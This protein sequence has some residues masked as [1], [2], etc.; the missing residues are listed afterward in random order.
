[1]CMNKEF[2]SSVSSEV[3]PSI[4][5]TLRRKKYEIIG[6]TV[7]LTTIYFC[8]YFG[9]KDS[10]SYLVPAAKYCADER[11]S[12]SSPDQACSRSDLFAF[13]VVGGIMQ[14]YLG[15]TGFF[16]WHWRK[17]SRQGGGKFDTPEKRIFGFVPDAITLNIG[18][19]CFQL[20]D[21]I[22]TLAIEE[23][24][25]FVMVLHHI[26]A[27]LSAAFTLEFQLMHHY[28]VLYG[29]CSE[30]SSIFLVVIDTV[31]YFPVDESKYPVL[32]V[33]IAMCQAMFVITFFIY[34]VVLWFGYGYYFYGDMIQIHK[35]EN[36][37]DARKKEK[38][39]VEKY[40]PGKTP[41]LVFFCLSHFLLG[42]M[43]LYWFGFAILPALKE[44]LMQ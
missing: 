2:K 9:L 4:P 33:I 13:Q 14:V 38:S 26:L 15:T 41:I 23:H 1:M 39:S 31:N 11:S 19:V 12:T 43:Q 42:C 37:I 21:L 16:S 35:I 28:S 34:R 24:R 40:R 32:A 36:D 17:N 7:L 20:W 29:G 27:G 3:P 25:E 44:A 18:H 6:G 10:G 30:I 5:S 8:F 22:F